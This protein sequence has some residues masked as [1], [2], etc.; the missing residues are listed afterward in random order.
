MKRTVKYALFLIAIPLIIGSCTQKQSSV[1]EYTETIVTYPFSD[2]SPLPIIQTKNDIYPYSRIDGF[3]HTAQAQ[4]WKMVKL[5]NDYIEVYIM[6]AQGGKVW[7]AVDKSTGKDFI[8]MNDVVKFRDVAMRGPWTSGGIEWNSGVIGHHPG[9]ASPVHYRVYTDDK[10]TAHCVVGGMDLPSH[11]QWR[12][13]ISLPVNTS[14]FETKINWYNATPYF[15]AYYHWNNAAV[16][17]AEDLRFYFPGNYRLGHGGQ[18]DPWP[19]DEDGIDRSWYKNNTHFGHCSYHIAGSVDN[20]FVS[21]YHDEDFGS[22][23]WSPAYGAP[24][25]KIWMWSHARNGAIWEDLLTDTHGQYVEVQAG[26]ML[27]QNSFS[28]GR[29]PF[30]QPNF[31]PY[32]A[33]SWVERWFPVRE[34]GGVTR[35][36]ESG[37]INLIYS[38][39]GM[40]LLFS[41]MREISEKLVVLVDGNEVLGEMLAILPSAVREWTIDGISEEDKLEV[42]LGSEQLF[43]SDQD[44]IMDRPMAAPSDALDDP[45]ILAR[46]LENRRSYGRALDTY[47]ELLEKEPMHLAATERVAELYARRGELDK[48]LLYAR[49]VLEMDA[50]LPEANFIYGNI[51]KTLGNFKDAKD[52]FRWAMRSLEFRSASLQLL[53]EISLMEGKL[54]LA[55]EQ[56]TQALS[57]NDLNMNSHKVRAIAQRKLEQGNAAEQSLAALLETDPLNHFALFESYLLK[58]GPGTLDAFNQAFQSEMARD[59]YL[60]TALFYEG[61]GLHEEAVKLLEEA[62]AYPVVDYWLAWLQ[63]E[64]REKSKQSLENALK[65]DPAYIFPYRTKTLAVLEWAALQSPSWITDYY[66]ALIL[67]NRDRDAEAKSLLDKWGDEPDFVPFYYSRASLAGLQSDAALK[68]MQKALSID[69]DQWR[70]YRVLADIYDRRGD[71]VSALAVTEE[72][73]KKFP[74]NYILDLAYSK[75]LTLNDKHEQSLE[76]LHEI[77][78]LPFE[79]EN[80]G[81]DLWEYNYMVLA[82]NAYKSGDYEQALAYVDKSEEYP[83]NLG[84]GSPSYPDY[85]DQDQLRIMIYDKTGESAK[86]REAQE[87]IR[88]YTERFG[89]KRGRSFFGQGFSST[90]VQPF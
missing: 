79:G 42:L 29:T 52:G 14:Y 16:K 41:P 24:G 51:Q 60:E 65:A 62:P 50:Y 20:Y 9:G 32:N 15:Q 13:D 40:K 46:E 37:T 77:N 58:P 33:D 76:V 38:E 18:A 10:G 83:E 26:R 66:S 55:L 90:V 67:W 53:S 43:C 35:V 87:K 69:P 3:S 21:Y 34:T 39:G 28:S 78:V 70:V 89:E 8:Y 44:Y 6:P 47:L 45:Y 85:R 2:T 12:V 36:A 81:H 31:I 56:A 17:S 11:M 4:E 82:F 72:G 61:L 7:G 57:Y 27:N 5:E 64:D 25:K 30:K 48:A 59:E 68:D 22:G 73:H 71:Y 86:S 63:R 23:H 74:G 19:V 80:T 1:E 75:Y 84:S 88:E 49:K 54:E